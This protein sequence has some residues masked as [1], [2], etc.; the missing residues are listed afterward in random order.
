MSDLLKSQHPGK[1]ILNMKPTSYS[2]IDDLTFDKRIRGETL[3]Q[4]YD[5]YL[6]QRRIKF[7]SQSFSQSFN[8]SMSLDEFIKQIGYKDKTKRN[9]LVKINYNNPFITSYYDNNV[10]PN[11]FP[12]K[13]NK[14]RYLLHTIAPRHS[15]IIDLMFENKQYCYLVAININT[16]KLWVESTALNIETNDEE[17]ND[18]FMNKAKQTLKSS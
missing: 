4:I 13:E 18:D 5:Y 14:K 6:K 2:S 16:R 3:E 7:S 10:Q 15:Y 11:S 12:L 1:T 9:A 8:P 17:S